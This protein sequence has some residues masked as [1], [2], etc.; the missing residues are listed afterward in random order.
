MLIEARRKDIIQKEHNTIQ[1]I[2][3][4]CLNTHGIFDSG[5]M[6]DTGYFYQF[7]MTN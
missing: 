4:Y 5:P 2:A 7:L 6:H 3:N 1:K